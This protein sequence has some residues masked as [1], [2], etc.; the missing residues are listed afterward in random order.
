[1]TLHLKNDEGIQI[2]FV[3]DIDKMTPESIHVEIETAIQKELDRVKIDN[4]RG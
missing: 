2:L 4:N 3:P 1:M